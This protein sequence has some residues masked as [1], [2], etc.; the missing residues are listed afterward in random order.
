VLSLL[1]LDAEF[2]GQMKSW[3]ESVQELSALGRVPKRCIEQ[4]RFLERFGQLIANSDMHFGNLAFLARGE[5]VLDIAPAYDMLPM[6]YAPQAGNVV[7]VEFSTPLPEPGDG[8]IWGSVCQAAAEFWDE[9]AQH[10]LVSR[11]FQR[12]ARDNAR[13]VADAQELAARLPT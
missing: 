8:A 13:T 7:D 6:R 9:V 2:V 3:T 5:R 1:A 11:D 4:A 12:A 10:P